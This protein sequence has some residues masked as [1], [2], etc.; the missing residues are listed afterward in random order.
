MGDLERRHDICKKRICNGDPQLQTDPEKRKSD[1]ENKVAKIY[2]FIILPAPYRG[3]SGKAVIQRELERMAEMSIGA[4]NEEA[5]KEEIAS[6]SKAFENY[7]S[8]I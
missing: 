5:I 8:E 3:T 2:D 7:E 4:N 6:I 1:D